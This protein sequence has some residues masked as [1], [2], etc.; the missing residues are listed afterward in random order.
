MRDG[1]EVAAEELAVD[2]LVFCFI[3]A[4]LFSVTGWMPCDHGMGEKKE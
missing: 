4:A 3:R 2:N 1:G